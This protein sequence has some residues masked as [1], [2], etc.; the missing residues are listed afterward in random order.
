MKQN[1]HFP[2]LKTLIS[3]KYS[4]QKLTEFS[5]GKDMLNAA[6]SNLDFFLFLEVHVFL[7]LNWTG[8]FGENIPHLHLE[9]PM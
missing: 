9:T 4:F 8:L 2:T 5:Q 1:E 7:Q 6:T 3:R